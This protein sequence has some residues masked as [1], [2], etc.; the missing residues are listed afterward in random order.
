MTKHLSW[1]AVLM[2]ALPAAAQINTGVRTGNGST[3]GM[4]TIK[5]DPNIELNRMR[6]SYEAKVKL[7][8]D[9]M[10]QKRYLD[11]RDAL[12]VAKALRTTDAQA[13]ELIDLYTKLDVAGM[14]MLKAAV[15]DYRGGKYKEAL[16]VFRLVSYQFGPLPSARAARDQLKKAENDTSA[17]AA[18]QQDK[19]EAMNEMVDQILDRF[20]ASRKAQEEK[21]G[22][23][24]TSQPADRVGRIRLMPQGEVVRVARMLESL[25]RLFPASDYGK[26]AAQDVQDL[27]A[28]KVF[29]PLL[30]RPG[31][32]DS[33][34]ALTRA[35]N[36]RKAGFKDK[37]I[38][39]F[40]EVIEKYPDS[41]EAAKA[42][43]ALAALE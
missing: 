37:A 38:A 41:N 35:E 22:K 16:R 7:A 43:E 20:F 19:A 30:R 26:Q 9:M 8:E 1:I 3:V 12:D 39:L 25:A 5:E 10:A 27:K 21:A 15:D 42:K 36:Y 23:T 40:R 4:G 11:A 6:R 31:D 2:A 33:G 18:I 32:S 17:Q 34:K 29:G 28:D 13:Q 24:P 14:D